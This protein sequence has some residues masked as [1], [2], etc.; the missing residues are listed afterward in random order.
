MVV[1][2]LVVAATIWST[3]I[4]QVP[5]WHR[6]D[7]IAACTPPVQVERVSLRTAYEVLNR[8][9]QGCSGPISTRWPR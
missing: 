9:A 1:A 8:T 6:S 4:E 3:P 7:T 2:Y 5:A